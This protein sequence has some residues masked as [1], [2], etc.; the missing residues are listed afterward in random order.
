[1]HTHTHTHTQDIDR[2]REST[3]P[4]PSVQV[5]A[6]PQLSGRDPLCDQKGKTE[7]AAQ[8]TTCHFLLQGIL[9]WYVVK[10][11]LSLIQALMKN[12]SFQPFQGD[13]LPSSLFFSVN[14][15]TIMLSAAAAAAPT[16]VRQLSNRLLSA[17]LART[18]CVPAKSVNVPNP[19]LP[20]SFLDPFIAH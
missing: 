16:A 4:Y 5:S 7:P 11:V 9:H 19:F 13:F 12:G 10:S 3:S 6:P 14:A 18:E 8:P 1:M 15:K 20:G 2:A 17:H